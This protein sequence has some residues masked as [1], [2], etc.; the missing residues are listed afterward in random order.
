MDLKN[1]RQN[2]ANFSH[3]HDCANLSTQKNVNKKK[4][5]R[6]FG[7]GSLAFF[8]GIGTL[9]GVLLAPMNSAQASV[10]GGATNSTTS[11][12][13]LDPEN[14]PVICT[15]ESGL[16]IKFH[17]TFNDYYAGNLE[18]GA[19]AGYSYVTMGKYNNNPINW[20]VIGM[21]ESGLGGASIGDVDWGIDQTPA[22][23]A[24]EDSILNKVA[25]TTIVGDNNALIYYLNSVGRSDELKQG[26]LLML[27]EG[28]LGSARFYNGSNN[29]G[30][31]YS[32]S[33]LKTSM[34]NIAKNFTDEEKTH[35]IPQTIN[36]RNNGW[37]TNTVNNALLFPLATNYY[38]TSDSDLAASHSYDSENKCN[39]SFCIEDYFDFTISSGFADARLMTTSM[40][41]LRSG[42]VQSTG[43]AAY[44]EA[45][46][47]MDTYAGTSTS[48]GVRPAFVLKI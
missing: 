33:S 4:W 22:G 3:N 7:A 18:T 48:Y 23:L 10:G 45:N 37:S 13:G 36:S 30:N 26:E 9:C 40:W 41:W 19:L 21:S 31:N 38:W 24:V 5:L 1:P 35:I 8:M 47:Y 43:G 27:S 12:L 42:T 25:N 20:V 28:I 32:S 29:M 16:E 15:T 2:P 11:P 17:Q 34:D 39:Q 6:I 46:G 44:C 14:D